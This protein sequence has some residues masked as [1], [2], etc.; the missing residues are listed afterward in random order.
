MEHLI[1]ENRKLKRNNQ[2]LNLVVDNAFNND[3]C[4]GYMIQAMEHVGCTREQIQIVID[5]LKSVFDE[6]T[7]AEAEGYYKNW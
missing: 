4:K 1:E 2:A 6:K 3:A 7:V 5:E